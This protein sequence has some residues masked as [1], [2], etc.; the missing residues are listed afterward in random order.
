MLCQSCAENTA[1]THIKTIV[2]GEFREYRLCQECA[3]K[4]GYMNLFDGFGIDLENFLGS[5]LSEGAKSASLPQLERCQKCGSSIADIKRT[6]KLG[7]ANCYKT[8]TAQIMPSIKRIHGNT[9]HT[10][11]IS[12]SATLQVRRA[13]ELEKKK[14]ELKRAIELQEF[15]RAAVLRDEILVLEGGNG[16]A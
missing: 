14:K 5:F 6:G 8:F 12:S 13:S 10:G 4:L 1:T 16:N 11:K 7:C 2:N 15:E 9:K 3:Q